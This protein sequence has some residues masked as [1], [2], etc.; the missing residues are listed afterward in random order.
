M[1]CHLAA[2]NRAHFHMMRIPNEGR[3]PDWQAGLEEWL[4]SVDSICED[5]C[6]RIAQE[7]NELTETLTVEKVLEGFRHLDGIEQAQRRLLR[8]HHLMN[9]TDSESSGEMTETDSKSSYEL[10]E[11]DSESSYE[12]G[13]ATS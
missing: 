1:W 7:M 9:E 13:A 6:N 11:T 12:Y 8:R 2:T 3:E 4:W 5:I 10:N